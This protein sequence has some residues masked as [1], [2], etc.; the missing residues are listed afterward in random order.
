[1]PQHRI[2]TAKGRWSGVGGADRSIPENAIRYD[3]DGHLG[4]VGW[5]LHLFSGEDPSP[6][7]TLPDA[8]SPL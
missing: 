2:P 3:P 4:R 5:G 7:T 8:D 6:N 1:M